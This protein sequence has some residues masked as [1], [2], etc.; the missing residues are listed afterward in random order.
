[1]IVVIRVPVRAIS[2]RQAMSSPS[3]NSPPS[4][5][6][7]SSSLPLSS[8][9][10]T[11]S[12]LLPPSPSLSPFLLS[13]PSLSAWSH[14]PS[15][16]LLLIFRSYLPS[17]SD[18]LHLTRT[19]TA[20]RAALH[21]PLSFHALSQ[22]QRWPCLDGPHFIAKLR[23][24]T[25][26]AQA[27]YHAASFSLTSPSSASAHSSSFLLPSSLSCGIS[28]LF[29]PQPALNAST[30]LMVTSAPVCAFKLYDRVQEKVVESISPSLSFSAVD[31]CGSSVLLAH[32]HTSILY[33]YDLTSHELTPINRR[34]RASVTRDDTTVK[35]TSS[36]TCVRMLSLDDGRLI[37]VSGSYDATVRVWDLRSGEEMA[38][39]QSDNHMT[40]WCVDVHPSGSLICAGSNDKAVRVFRIGPGSDEGGVEGGG[41]QGGRLLC[42]LEGHTRAP[43]VTKFDPFDADRCLFSAGYDTIIRQ[44]DYTRAVQLRKFRGHSNIIFSLVITQHVLISSSRD[45][46]VHVHDRCSRAVLRV[47]TPRI[48]GK[49]GGALGGGIGDIKTVIING[50][51]DCILCGT[52]SGLLYEW[53][54]RERGAVQGDGKRERPIEDSLSQITDSGFRTLI[55]SW[56]ERLGRK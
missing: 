20:Y 48:G 38:T 53:N 27:G 17:F 55:K 41:D 49:E 32:A 47:L 18:F 44:W 26:F 45:G 30:V 13:P 15:D 8:S 28:H 54:L 19:C 4:P 43:M 14:L 1:M 10:S 39:L 29:L 23:A 11:S 25:F 24:V 52:S 31:V 16:L 37:G 56:K 6:S 42:K 51:E 50:R 7:A 2:A 3:S 21:H 35:H 46:T 40:V 5:L 22:Q 36:V 34:R 33:L 12:F 9:L